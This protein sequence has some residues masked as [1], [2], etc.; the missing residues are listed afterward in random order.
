MR[1]LR[2]VQTQE[3]IVN[4]DRRFLGSQRSLFAKNNPIIQI[5]CI[6]GWL[7]VPINSDKWSSTVHL[8]FLF[9]I[10]FLQ[11]SRQAY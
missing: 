9:M 3:L 11:C 6:F 7:A 5:F 2:K 1:R 10:N 4:S 8:N